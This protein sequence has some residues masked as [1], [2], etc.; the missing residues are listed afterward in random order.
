MKTA[1]PKNASTQKHKISNRSHSPQVVSRQKN[2][3]NQQ[4]T[5]NRRIDQQPEETLKICIQLANHHKKEAEEFKVKNEVLEYRVR[6]QMNDMKSLKK[7]LDAIKASLSQNHAAHSKVLEG[8]RQEN[9]QLRTKV[10]ELTLEN[11]MLK[12][13]FHETES[14]I[15]VGESK[16]SMLEINPLTLAK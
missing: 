10:Q 7:E 3:E 1:T 13:K 15:T 12:S 6:E 9:A 8:L 11:N 4:S 2:K 16:S 14:I 5:S